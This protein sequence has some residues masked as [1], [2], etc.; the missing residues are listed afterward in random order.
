MEKLNF[1][2]S[3][4]K[5]ICSHR[6]AKC[7]KDEEVG[8]SV[9]LKKKKKWMMHYSFHLLYNLYM[10]LVAYSKVQPV[11]DISQTTFAL[12]KALPALAR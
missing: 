5:K 4:I 8:T 1:K 9:A 10:I 12:D 6:R 3:V 11:C 2:N 7:S